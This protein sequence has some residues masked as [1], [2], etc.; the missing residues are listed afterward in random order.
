MFA[1]IDALRQFAS[2]M[3]KAAKKTSKK[4]ARK[5]TTKKA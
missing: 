2:T 4:T 3:K 5:R 1:L